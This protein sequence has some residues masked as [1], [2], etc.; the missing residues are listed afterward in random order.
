MFSYIV[1]KLVLVPLKFKVMMEFHVLISFRQ[2]NYVIGVK[3]IANH[4]TMQ[5]PNCQ[6]TSVLSMFG[7]QSCRLG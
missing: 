5:K 4:Y 6:K 7:Y 1:S 3:S 2:G